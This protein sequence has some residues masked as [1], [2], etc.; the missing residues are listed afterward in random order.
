MFS[1]ITLKGAIFHYID[2]SVK[3]L[4]ISLEF[5]SNGFELILV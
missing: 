2:E 4:E 1:Y 5:N 3:D